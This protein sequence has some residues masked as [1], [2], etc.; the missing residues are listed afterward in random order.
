MPMPKE[1]TSANGAKA[2]LIGEFHESIEVAN[3]DV[4]GCGE[5]DCLDC[6]DEPETCVVMVPVSWTTIKQIY[7]RIVDAYGI[8]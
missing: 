2:L 7:K 3:P 6:L 5:N 1:L 8:D 4:C